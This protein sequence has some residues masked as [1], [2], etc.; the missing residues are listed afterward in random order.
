LL[1]P[2]SPADLTPQQRLDA[3][4]DLEKTLDRVL[5]DDA[6]RDANPGTAQLADALQRLRSEGSVPA[7]ASVELE[8]RLMGLLPVLLADLRQALD[9]DRISLDDLPEAVRSQWLTPDGQARILVRPAWQIE[10]NAELRAFADAVLAEVPH[11]TGTPIVV[12]GGGRAVV[13]AFE[14]ASALALVL[15][16]VLLVAI[17]RNLRDVL[18]VLAP[19]ALA[20]VLTA[21][22]AV[23][24][25][26]S[27]NFANVIVLP[28]LLGLG[29]SGAIHVV[30]RERQ[31]GDIL[32]T[33]TPRAVVFSGLTTIA[34]FGSLALS[35]HLGLAS[36]GLLLSIAIVWSLV[37]SLV[38][39]PS[40]LVVAAGQRVRA[41][42]ARPR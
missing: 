34:S 1:E 21:A 22:S 12:V 40:L 39:L 24:L 27:L 38:V 42:A 28:L 13:L 29:V 17:L 9:A 41:P 2:D 37:C 8:T 32:G 16:V 23:L 3:V 30:M 35:S 26:L 4:Q 36:M 20:A 25:G 6:A 19:I 15:I 7:T 18:L 11:A 10:T 33:S 31:Q 5:S 14:Q